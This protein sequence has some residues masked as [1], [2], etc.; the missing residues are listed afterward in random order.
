MYKS[1]LAVELTLRELL[2]APAAPTLEPLRPDPP[3]DPTVELGEGLADVGL[4]EI[5]T[6][7]ADDQI[8]NSKLDF[9]NFPA[10]GLIR[11]LAE[12]LA[13]AARPRTSSPGWSPPPSFR[14]FADNLMAI[15]ATDGQLR[16]SQGCRVDVILAGGSD[17]FPVGEL[18]EP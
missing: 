7:P 17:Q 6:P 16:V 8:E 12:A 13:T 10:E 2:P 11:R 18:K 5:V 4:A 9:G 14:R 1:H 3:Q 15:H